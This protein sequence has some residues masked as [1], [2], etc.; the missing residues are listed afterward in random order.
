MSVNLDDGFC[1]FFFYFNTNFSLIFDV[2]EV[3]FPV[4]FI[5]TSAYINH[6]SYHCSLLLPVPVNNLNTF[7]C[8]Q[9]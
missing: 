8:L 5:I 4:L 3:N 6:Y 7:V 9:V 2:I 1:N